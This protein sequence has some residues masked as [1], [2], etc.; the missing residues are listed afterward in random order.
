MKKRGEMLA[1]ANEDTPALGVC[2]REAVTCECIALRAWSHS[3]NGWHGAQR[4]LTSKSFPES[5]LHPQ[6]VSSPP[7]GLARVP[8]WG[9]CR[10]PIPRPSVASSSSSIFVAS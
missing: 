8:F 10:H 1:L 9:I 5:W 2:T 6:L 7:S 4:I 3:H